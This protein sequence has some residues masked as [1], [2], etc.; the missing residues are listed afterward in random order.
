MVPIRHGRWALHID[1]RRRREN[2]FHFILHKSRLLNPGLKQLDAS[3]ATD[4]N[5][6]LE[7]DFKPPHQ[8]FGFTPT[9]WPESTTRDGPL[10]LR[11]AHII[12][13]S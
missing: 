5:Q 6:Q 9:T 7:N 12:V 2:L 3:I 8:G 1:I 4:R 13:T 11:G 10:H